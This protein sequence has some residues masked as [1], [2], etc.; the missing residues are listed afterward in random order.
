MSVKTHRSLSCDAARVPGWEYKPECE[1]TFGPREMSKSGLRE[2]AAYDGWS[3]VA[4]FDLCGEHSCPYTHA[5]TRDWCDRPFCRE[6]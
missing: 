6:S 4:G 3:R 1:A 5:H 2:E